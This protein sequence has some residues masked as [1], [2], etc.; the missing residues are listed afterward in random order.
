M[1]SMKAKLAE[2]WTNKRLVRNTA[3]IGGALLLILIALCI[4]IHMRANIQRMY[5]RARN[6]IQEQVYQDMIDMAELFARV[7]DPNVDVQNKLVPSLK[8]EYAAVTALNTALIEGFGAQSAVLSQEQ[9]LAFDAAF[10]EYASAYREG[11]ATGLA[12]DDMAACIAGVQL[13]IDERYKPEVE[14]EEPVLVIGAT[15]APQN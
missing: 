12:R 11:R 6:Q 9:L 10:D 14:E 7:D 13:M 3:L 15:A 8:A 5:S 4:T 1:E 2:W